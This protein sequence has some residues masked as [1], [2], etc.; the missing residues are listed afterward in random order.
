MRFSV[1][2]NRNPCVS[3]GE[4]LK[5]VILPLL[6]H[7]FLHIDTLADARVSVW[8]ETETCAELEL[9]RRSRRR[10]A[11]RRGRGGGAIAACRADDDFAALGDG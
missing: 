1:G 8:L 7:G 3:K 6:T 4:P 10:K 9:P 5:R 2:T 11:E